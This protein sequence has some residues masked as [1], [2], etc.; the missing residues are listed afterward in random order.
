MT[1]NL[2]MTR[3][4][5]LFSLA[6][7]LMAGLQTA[8]AN[9]GGSIKVS[10]TADFFNSRFHTSS[11]A[12]YNPGNQVASLNSNQYD[13]ILKPKL[14]L[15]L[16]PVRFWL[17]P[18]VGTR[19]E[20]VHGVQRST[21]LHHV[22]EMGVQW[23][24][25]PRL[26]VSAERG[27]VLW[28]PSLFTSPSNPFFAATG[29]SNPFIEINSRDFVRARYAPNDAWAISA[30]SN[31]RLGRDEN[32]YDAFH[33]INAIN[34]EHSGPEHTVN[35]V[36][37]QRKGIW[38]AGFFGQWTVSDAMLLYTDIGV[39]QGSD[40]RVAMR[41]G[42]PF[43]WSLAARPQ[44]RETDMVA[45][46]SYTQDNGDTLSFEWRHNQQGLNRQENADLQQATIDALGSFGNPAAAPGA[47]LFLQQSSNMKNRSLRRN[48]LYMQYIL[49]EIK[50]NLG[51]NFL[52]LHNLD[53]RGTQWIGVVNYNLSSSTRVSL[54][55]VANS[56]SE[57]SEFRRYFNFATFLGLKY[58]Y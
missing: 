21:T 17:A 43:G 40:A 10:G 55:V 25:T 28:G 39:R 1:D 38:H 12:F 44:Q 30:I 36:A 45:G 19:H 9:E 4:P 56:G 26:S 29:Q 31:V 35:L 48:Y 34:L 32:E 2:H 41:D 27:V 22:Q 49:R 15:N 58:Y 8:N 33:R 46:I 14:S 52:A 50:P 5:A 37:S 6:A 54:N 57:R 42:S 18:R 16:E 3:L 53:D 23:N 47:G 24:L 7:L 20:S 13:L 51:I 11:S